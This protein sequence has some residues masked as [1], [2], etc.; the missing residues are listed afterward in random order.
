MEVTH[1]G[2]TSPDEEMLEVAT[3]QPVE[4][5]QERLYVG[6]ELA[7]AGGLAVEVL[8]QYGEASEE[9]H[10]ALLDG[11]AD[12]SLCELLALGG[13]LISEVSS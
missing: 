9:Q 12:N 2:T 7:L 6:E 4:K 8:P 1:R 5:A 3:A 13:L 11:L 10:H